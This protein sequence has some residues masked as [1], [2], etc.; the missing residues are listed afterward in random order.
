M[1]NQYFNKKNMYINHFFLL[2]IFIFQFAL[3]ILIFGHVGLFPQDNLEVG[4]PHDYI[5]SKIYNG[6]FEYL[7]YFLG[8]TYKWYFFENIFYPIN[9]LHLLFD[10]KS[11]FFI[12]YFLNTIIA[13]TTFYLLCKKLNFSK[14]QSSLGA[15]FY[16]TLVS[17]DT[18][19]HFDLAFMPYLLYLTIKNKKLATKNYLIILF[20]GLGGGLSHNVLAVFF[21]PLL[22]RCFSKEVNNILSIKILL[23]YY[24]GLFIS[25]IHLFNIFLSEEPYHRSEML[26]S[27]PGYIISLKQSLLIPFLEFNIGGYYHFMRIFLIISILS[28]I[29]Y[30]IITKNKIGL[31][32]LLFVTFIVFIRSIF[33]TEFLDIF[34]TGPFAALKGLNFMRIDKIIPITMSLIVMIALKND[35]FKKINYLYIILIFVAVYFQ[36]LAITIKK[37]HT[38]VRANLKTE[39]FIE[40]KELKKEKKIIEIIKMIALKSNYKNNSYNLGQEIYSWDSYFHKD[41][42]AEIKKIVKNKRVMSVGLDPLVAVVNDMRVIDGYHTLYH[43]YY[44]KKFRKIIAEEV[45]RSNI[46]I[47]YYDNWANRVYAFYNDKNNLLI[48]FKEAKNLGASFVISGFKIKSENLKLIKKIPGDNM[49]THTT[50]WQCYLCEKAEAYYLYE[51]N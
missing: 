21:I 27:S 41:E 22:A 7:D 34:F 46:L 15:V 43:A 39:K 5:I 3:P 48:N 25:D 38:S 23:T 14:F 36:Q 2:L 20:F 42:Y 26:G 28:G 18:P 45:D 12:K 37:L 9:I 6:K 19:V 4:V 51:I 16:L 49:Y 1:N 50:N 17:V 35:K 32:L 8:G 30:V 33:G 13:Y 40:L 24:V 29:L 11:F 31:L 10:I 47:G 44:K